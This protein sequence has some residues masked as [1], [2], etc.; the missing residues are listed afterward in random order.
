MASIS[1]SHQSS[2]TAKLFPRE[3]SHN[4]SPRRKIKAEKERFRRASMTQE[5]RAA[6]NSAAAERMQR[7]R[8][9]QR[10]LAF[11][12]NVHNYNLDNNVYGNHSTTNKEEIILMNDK[13]LSTFSRFLESDVVK[14]HKKSPICPKVTCVYKIIKKSTGSLGGN[15]HNGPIYGELTMGSMQRIV[16]YLVLECELDQASL[17]LDVGSGLGK[18]NF[19]VTQYP[20]VRV[21]IGIELETIRYQVM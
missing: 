19:H 9:R 13:E 17:F 2:C 15:G 7:M 14:N 3:I 1:C 6:Y 20:D 10:M 21:S 4:N 11:L 5:Q 8:V 12:F 18:P 16:N